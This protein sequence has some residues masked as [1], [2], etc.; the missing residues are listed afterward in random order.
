MPPVGVLADH[1]GGGVLALVLVEGQ[2][3]QPS[4][5]QSDLA[6][7]PAVQ[8]LAL[9]EPDVR[10]GETVLADVLQ[11]VRVFLV[12]DVAPKGAKGVPL[13]GVRHFSYLTRDFLG[14]SGLVRQVL[15]APALAAD[16]PQAGA[17]DEGPRLL[18]AALAPQQAALAS[19]HRVLD[20]GRHYLAF[21]SFFGLGFQIG[22]LSAH[23]SRCAAR[24][25]SK[26][27]AMSSTASV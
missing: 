15:G 26:A 13:V 19:G 27:A 4:Q 23:Q 11:H 6:A 25:A 9:A 24:Y 8:D 1:V 17:T 7:V 22:V 14:G 5:L 12:G 10:V 16:H 2:F 18:A 3:V 20:R 21:L